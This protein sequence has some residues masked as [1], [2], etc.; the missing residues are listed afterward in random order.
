MVTVLGTKGYTEAFSK[1]IEAEESLDFYKLNKCFLEFL[2][3]FPGSILDLGCGTGRDAAALAVMGHTVVAVEPTT[4][5]LEAAKKLHTSSSIRWL[6]DSLPHLNSL[7]TETFDFILCQ[8]VWQH[9]DDDERLQGFA[10]VAELLKPDGVFALT[11]RHGPPGVGTHYFDVDINTML[12]YA[13]QFAL[14]EVLRLEHL[15]SILPNKKA[16]TWTWLAFKKLDL[17][18]F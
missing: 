2:P 13:K 18:H 14:E 5:F 12:S 11:L 6:A 3:P 17:Q 8:G 15:P 16:V 1:F 4:A 9:I 7:Q 10:R